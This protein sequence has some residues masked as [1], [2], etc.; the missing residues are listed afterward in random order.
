MHNGVTVPLDVLIQ[1]GESMSLW[2]SFQAQTNG[3]IQMSPRS[4][5][6]NKRRAVVRLLAEDCERSSYY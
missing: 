5:N 1:S 6:V 2:G 3:K 4:I